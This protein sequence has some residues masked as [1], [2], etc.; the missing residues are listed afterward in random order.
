MNSIK[1]QAAAL[2][3][4]LFSCS[5]KREPAGQLGDLSF[6]VTATD[7]AAKAFHQGLLLLHSFEYDDAAE[8]FRKAQ[9]LDPTCVMAFWGEAMT[10]NHSLWS[11]QDYEKAQDVL[12]RLAMSPEAR[13]EK[14]ATEIEKGFISAVDVLYG[15]GT[16]P[17]RDKAY[18]GYMATLFDKFPDSHEVASF[19]ALALMGAVPVGRDEEVYKKGALIAGEILKENPRHPG[20]LHYLIHA[21]DDPVHAAEALEAANRY[22]RVAPAAGHALHMPSHI[23]LVL[24]MWEDVVNSNESSWQASVDRKERK[25][26]DN[27]ALDYHSLHWLMYAYLQQGRYDTALH[28]VGMMNQFQREVPTEYSDYYDDVMRVTYGV[29]TG[30]WNDLTGID[31]ENDSV[32]SISDHYFKGLKANHN[33]DRVALHSVIRQ[34]EDIRIRNS[35][36]LNKDGIALCSSAGAQIDLTQ[37][38]V[39]QAHVMEMEL[40]AL[41]SMR[42][43]DNTAAEQWLKGATALEDKVSFVYGPPFIAKPSHEM[44]GE[45]LLTQNRPDEAKTHFEATLKRA[46]RR[47]LALKGILEIARISNDRE[48]TEAME[49]ELQSIITDKRS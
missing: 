40:R 47:V 4:I 7:S 21:D 14:A 30:N 34:M 33:N 46:P 13:R 20:A 8:A 11:E 6:K 43:K 22:S 38:R 39:D 35:S 16:K 31:E 9:N 19:Y 24:G 36:R 45:F 25:G 1:L 28:L 2:A 26:L 29:E 23:Y 27:E 15:E 5:G 42:E 10:Y 41:L 37:Q 49:K 3:V 48:T 17:E 12:N 44:Y 32:L 18:S